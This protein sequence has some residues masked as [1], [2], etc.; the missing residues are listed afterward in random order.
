MLFNL[1][2]S[3]SRDERAEETAGIPVKQTDEAVNAAAAAA[4]VM[5]GWLS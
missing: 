4:A 5:R 3:G 1:K 2:S